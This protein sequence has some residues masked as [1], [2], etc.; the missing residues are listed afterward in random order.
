VKKPKGDNMLRERGLAVKII[1]GGAAVTNTSA[2][3]IGAD[4]YGQDA[5]A[6]LKI[7]RKLMNGGRIE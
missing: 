1:V 4:A 2:E 5:W 7:I 6:G 3:T